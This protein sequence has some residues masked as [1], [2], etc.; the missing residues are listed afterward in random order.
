MTPAKSFSLSLCLF[1]FHPSIYPPIVYPSPQ[2]GIRGNAAASSVNQ[3]QQIVALI[4]QGG[5][6]SPQT[7]QTLAFPGDPVGQS[8]WGSGP[9]YSRL[10]EEQGSPEWGNLLLEGEAVRG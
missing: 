2:A 4:Q 8:R 3:Q 1:S 7:S 9:H 5:G 10:V 6:S